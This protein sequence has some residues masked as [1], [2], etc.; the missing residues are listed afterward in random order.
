MRARQLVE[1]VEPNFAQL[2]PAL[3]FDPNSK[4][5]PSG[6]NYFFRWNDLNYRKGLPAGVE[7]DLDPFIQVGITQGGFIFSYDNTVS[8]YRQVKLSSA[9]DCSNGCDVCPVG[10]IAYEDCI[11]SIGKKEKDPNMKWYYNP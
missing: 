4:T 11:R 3:I 9:A 7:I 8:N 2:E 10:H 6:S 1:R 5:N